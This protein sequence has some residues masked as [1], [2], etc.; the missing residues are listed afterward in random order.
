[1][2]ILS[3][4]KSY[5]ITIF[6]PLIILYFETLKQAIAK[7]KLEKQTILKLEKSSKTN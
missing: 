7:E 3:T 2:I 6:N 1:M 5:S 4:N